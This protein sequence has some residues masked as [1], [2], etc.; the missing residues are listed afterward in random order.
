MT[1]KAG[2]VGFLPIFQA[3]WIIKVFKR[4]DWNDGN[5]IT[6][7]II[8]RNILVITRNDI[9]IIGLGRSRTKVKPRIDEIVIPKLS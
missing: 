5:Y 7:L 9:T 8:F 1:L 3:I 6:I 4:C 2:K